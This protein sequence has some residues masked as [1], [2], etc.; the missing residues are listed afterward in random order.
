[1]LDNTVI[2]HVLQEQ[3]PNLL[4][5]YLFGS[6][7]QGQAQQDS[8]VDLA[9]LVD[10]AKLD[11]LKLWENAQTLAIKLGRDVDLVDLHQAS[12][13]LQ[14]QIIQYGQRLWAKNDY[15]DEYELFILNEKLKFDELRQAQLQD[16]QQR[17]YVYAK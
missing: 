15:A 13:V 10:D 4:A 11:S 12:T 1:M 17:G 7:A 14:Y 3:Y 6:F 2:I 8:D 16:I 9:V 5:I